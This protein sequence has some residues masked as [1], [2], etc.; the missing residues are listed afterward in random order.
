MCFLRRSDTVVC[1]PRTL[2]S[3]ERHTL[4]GK[5]K[6]NYIRIGP[7]TGRE[8]DSRLYGSRQKRAA[9]FMTASVKR[10]NSPCIERAKR[11]LYLFC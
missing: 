6:E 9:F 4:A 10:L 11:N 2:P 7:E 5:E 8:R 3:E 1:D